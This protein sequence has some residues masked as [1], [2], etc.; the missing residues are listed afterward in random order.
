MPMYFR[1]FLFTFVGINLIGTQ[2]VEWLADV[3]FEKSVGPIV[4]LGNFTIRYFVAFPP[5]D[6]QRSDA[7]FEATF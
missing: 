2:L 1:T 3:D 4:K 5:N 7:I 6:T